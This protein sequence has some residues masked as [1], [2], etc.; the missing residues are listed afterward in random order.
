MGI[1]QEMLESA[2]QEQCKSDLFMKGLIRRKFANIGFALNEKQIAYVVRRLR[3][4]EGDATK[5]R[6]NPKH[7]L[8]ADTV[9]KERLKAPIS[10]H[11]GEDDIEGAVGE[12]DSGLPQMM[13]AISEKVSSSLLR[14]L[15]RDGPTFL[16]ES[17]RERLAFQVRLA[18][19]WRKAFYLI[20]LF[21]AVALQSGADFNQEEHPSTSPVSGD[22]VYVLTRLHARACQVSA[23]II[24]LLKAGFAD[25]AHARWRTLHEIAVVST[26]VAN[27]G[28]E[29]ACRYLAHEAVESNKAAT[30]YQRHCHAI[31]YEPL[32][33][34]EIAEIRKRYDAA[35]QRF[36]KEFGSSYGWAAYA[37]K[38]LKP[39]FSDIEQDVKLD[40][41]SPFYRLASH[42]VHAN[43]KGI[44]VKLGLGPSVGKVLLAG[45]SN[46][47]MADPAQG[48]ALSL[49]QTTSALLGT[50]PNLD[51]IVV[52][53][54][55]GK[56]EMEI[57][58]IFTD[59]QR[60]IESRGSTTVVA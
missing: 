47:G 45:P 41:L 40:T 22:V 30:Q 34:K 21:L 32:D 58:K 17:D 54:M 59:I 57:A 26:F 42:N 39:T 11:L 5:I 24:A 53:K 19:T 37:L 4:Y 16:K 33:P 52:M 13:E 12:F 60:R 14:Q 56:L 49:L 7:L 36:G 28:G 15:K 18:K 43:P 51:G 3:H 44:S 10:L 55:L 8:N 1:L 38:K 9:S 35:L 20:E 48:A 31:G 6:I 25:G 50:R 29:T 23:E 2:L 27:H 46:T